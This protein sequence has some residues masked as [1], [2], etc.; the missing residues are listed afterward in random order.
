MGQDAW[1]KVF[2]HTLL[3]PDATEAKI[4]QL[5]KEGVAWGFWSVCIHPVWVSFAAECLKQ[6]SAGVL[7]TSQDSPPMPVLCSVVG[8]PSGA[9][10]TE[11]KVQEALLAIKQGASEIDMVLSLGHYLSEST[12]ARSLAR[13]DL[14]AVVAACRG[15]GV[16]VKL[17][18]ETGY[19][20][21][22]QINQLCDWSVEAGAAFVKT[23]TGFGPRGASL[24]DIHLMAH[25]VQGTGTQVKASGG[26]KDYQT[27]RMLYDAGAQRIGSSQSVAILQERA[28]LS[29]FSSL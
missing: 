27:A 18:F 14:L 15:H 9:H 23:S 24:E 29:P 8:F 13:E 21:P 19:L 22:D 10:R 12:R 2:D 17:I 3:R 28:Q 1:S 4:A 5:V 11:T 16:G 7:G 20:V 25:R 26:I 6:E